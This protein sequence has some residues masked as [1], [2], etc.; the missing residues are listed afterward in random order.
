LDDEQAE[1]ILAMVD[2]SAAEVAPD[3]HADS[4]DDYADLI[5][6]EHVLPEPRHTPSTAAPPESRTPSSSS[7]WASPSS[8]RW[9]SPS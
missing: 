1:L 5:R 6:H 9:P 7:A 2:A 8:D 4:F 3:E